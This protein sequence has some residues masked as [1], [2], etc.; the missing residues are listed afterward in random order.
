L[1]IITLQSGQYLE[2]IIINNNIA[3][4]ELI[5]SLLP[6]YKEKYYLN[7]QDAYIILN[8]LQSSIN[9]TQYIVQEGLDYGF[10]TDAGKQLF[11]TTFNKSKFKEGTKKVYMRNGI[12]G[13]EIVIEITSPKTGHDAQFILNLGSKNPI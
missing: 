4:V 8:R 6:I 1:P 9:F 5:K 10:L 7:K 11:S 12:M 13:T 3:N 2:D